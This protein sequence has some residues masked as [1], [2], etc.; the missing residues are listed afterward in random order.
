MRVPSARP[1]MVVLLEQLDV[2]KPQRLIAK[3]LRKVPLPEVW[4]LA[5]VRVGRNTYF[6]SHSSSLTGD[7][8]RMYIPRHATVQHRAF[9][10][11]GHAPAHRDSEWVV[12]G[13]QHR[14]L[15]CQ[16]V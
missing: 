8:P 15:S 16:D 9:A 13:R 3:S 6:L 4:R 14:Q 11:A 7:V 2:R 1:Q 5:H 10:D 12:V